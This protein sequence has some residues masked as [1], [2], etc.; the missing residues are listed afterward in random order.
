VDGKITVGLASHWPFFT[1]LS[2]F[3]AALA[4]VPPNDDL[5]MMTARRLICATM[6][7]Q[8]LVKRIT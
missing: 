2:D 8:W 4:Y 1:D 5:A 6:L 3:T 7:P